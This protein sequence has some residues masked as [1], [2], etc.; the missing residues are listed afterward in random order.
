MTIISDLSSSGSVDV[1]TEDN[2]KEKSR[3]RKEDFNQFKAATATLTVMYPTNVT[4]QEPFPHLT[5]SG[6]SAKEKDALFE[7]LL[8]ESSEI[9]LAF[10]MLE[11]N[12]TMSLLGS[13]EVDGTCIHDFLKS[14]NLQHFKVLAGLYSTGEVMGNLNEFWSF[15]DYGLLDHITHK[16]GTAIDRDNLEKYKQNLAE[17]SQRRLFEC[18]AN[19]AAPAKENEKM[20]VL[21]RRDRRTFLSDLTLNEVKIFCG[22][23]KKQMDM[24]ECDMRLISYERDDQSLELTFAILSSVSDGL[25]PLSDDKKEKLEYLDVWL[26]ECED[27]SFYQECAVSP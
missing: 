24:D 23:F 9:R 21:K 27:E 11:S 16:F 1:S 19:I 18:P 5:T 3:Q 15:F 4:L 2:P 13:S 20:L 6:M 10:T 17:Y 14:A 8:L 26:L 22:I 7:R 12:I 25:F